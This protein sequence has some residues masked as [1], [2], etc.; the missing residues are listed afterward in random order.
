MRIHNTAAIGFSGISV[1]GCSLAISH[2]SAVRYSLVMVGEMGDLEI[3][4]CCLVT[5][6]CDRIQILNLHESL[7]SA[8]PK[9]TTLRG[10]GLKKADSCCES[11]NLFQMKRFLNCFLL[12]L[13][14]K[15]Q[16]P[17]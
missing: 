9:K 10:G 17:L 6:E 5:V 14:P 1:Q 11:L 8:R 4:A 3:S 13:S 7:H 2:N 12:K 16:S 15:T